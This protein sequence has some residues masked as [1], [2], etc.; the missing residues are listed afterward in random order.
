MQGF[1]V[2]AG[3]VIGHEHIL[4]QVNCQDK[5][6]VI[7]VKVGEQEYMVGVVCDG[8]SAGPHSEVGAAL[9]S[10]FLV[11]EASRLLAL[12]VS[13]A[14]LPAELYRQTLG[15]L[16]DFNRL[17]LGSKPSPS[18][19][20]GLAKQYLLATVVGFVVGQ[21]E[22]VFFWA[23]DGIII[24]NDQFYNIDENNTP[25]YLIYS[26]LDPLQLSQAVPKRDNFETMFFDTSKIDRL[27]VWT[28]GFEPKL[29]EQIWKLGGS[30]SL[31]RKLNV[32]AN[33]KLFGDDT[34]GITLERVAI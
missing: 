2:K 6:R 13:I 10:E 26:L 32:W 5:Y 25:N 19:L 31:Q 7:D 11:R 14:D 24:V 20:S 16:H 28:D 12:E 29:C 33:Q 1:E 23:G 3:S 17:L 9:Q 21:A 34:T 8:C 30:R 18:E 27:A 15:F 22:T 4:R